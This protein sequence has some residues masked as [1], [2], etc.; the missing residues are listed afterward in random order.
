M[1]WVLDLDGVVWLG[2]DPI[3]G[4]AEAVSRLRAAGH[5]VLFVSNNSSATLHEYRAKLGDAGIEAEEE[6]II[7]SAIAGASIVDPDSRALLVAGAGV[8][9]A[10]KARGIETVREGEADV[11]VVGWH[12]D[13]DFG[14]L[15]AGTR[16]VF[17]GARLVAT[18]DDPTYPSPDGPLPGAGSIL[19]A[20][21]R[22]T[23]VKAEVA[24][25]PNDPMAELVRE[26]IDGDSIMVGDRASTDGLLAR[27]IGIR[28]ALVMSGIT[29]EDDLPADPEPDVTAPDLAALLDQEGID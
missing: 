6:D 4:S 27:K 8:E 20:I 19:A 10:L 22:A 14:R 23:G 16:A 29:G 18:N 1:T 3:D 5:S 24:G 7:T 13:F 15:V 25:K 11:V 9:E 21:E 12:K 28:F 2:D 17:K 26:R